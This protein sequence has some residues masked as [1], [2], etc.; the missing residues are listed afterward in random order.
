MKRF[1]RKFGKDFLSELPQSPAVYLFKDETGDVLYVGKAKSIRRRLSDYRNASRRKAHRKMRAIVR[2]SHSVEV[3]LQ[4]SEAAALIVENQLIRELHPPYNVDGAFEFLYPAIGTG[5]HEGRL[6]LCLSSEPELFDSLDLVWHGS[7]RPRSRARTAFDSLVELLGRLGHI[8]PRSR[9]PEAPRRKGSR[10]VALRRIPDD[11][12]E[13]TRRYLDGE[14]DS[15]LAALCTGLLES[16]DAR[17]VA[18]Q[19]EQELHFLED[20]YG[21]DVQRLRAARLAAGRVDPFVPREERDMLFIRKR[22]EL[23]N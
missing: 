18:A 21:H 14:D 16:R 5:S 19:V 3:R 2:E 6:L 11:F 7:F 20:F 4:E 22:L 10:L 12:L 1:D 23:S 15:L 8:E 13:K 17:E 9:L